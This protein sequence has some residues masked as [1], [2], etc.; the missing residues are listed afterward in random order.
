MKDSNIKY[1]YNMATIS[2]VSEYGN[3]IGINSNND[4]PYGNA[5]N[6]YYLEGLGTGIG[7]STG[8]IVETKSVTKED[9]EGQS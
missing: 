3:I 6:N 7:E 8:G 2:G 1:C 4:T 5:Y 9:F